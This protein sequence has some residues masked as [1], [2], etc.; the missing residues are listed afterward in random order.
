MTHIIHT[1][2]FCH[3]FGKGRIKINLDLGGWSIGHIFSNR[4]WERGCME[5]DV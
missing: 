5:K 4:E 2:Y 3:Q 1:L